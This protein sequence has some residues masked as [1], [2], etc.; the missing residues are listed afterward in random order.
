MAGCESMYFNPTCLSR[1][2]CHFAI[3]QM[4]PAIIRAKM[5]EVTKNADNVHRFFKDV[6]VENM[7]LVKPSFE[8]YMRK[9]GDLHN[10][11]G[12]LVKEH[13][14][15]VLG[16]DESCLEDCFDHEFVSFYE[17]PKCLK[18]CRCEKGLITIEREGDIYPRRSNIFG[19]EER[20]EGGFMDFM[21]HKNVGGRGLPYTSLYGNIFEDEE[22]L[23]EGEG[24][25]ELFGTSDKLFGGE[26]KRDWSFGDEEEEGLFSTKRFHHG[27]YPR[28]TGDRI[29]R[30]IKGEE[31]SVNW[32]ELMKYSEY[33]KKAWNFFKKYED[34]I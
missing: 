14:S 27:R 1:C 26:R 23:E 16:C 5:D 18:H 25:L 22:E 20:G 17:V 31:E 7:K 33:D 24:V 19:E 15:K 30:K 2:K 13:V 11:F 34:D 32:P 29:V 8:A 6:N 28:T 9:A 21:R 10:E 4:D 12:E 3:E